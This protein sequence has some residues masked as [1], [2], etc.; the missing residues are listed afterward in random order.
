MDTIFALASGVLPSGVA[1]VRLSGPRA[2][3][4]AKEIA[5]PLPT[6]RQVG[7]RTIRNRNN[8]ALDQGVVVAFEGPNSF[9]GEDVVEFQLHGSVAV[10]NALSAILDSFEGVRQAE[11]GEFTQRAFMNGR[12]DLTAAEGLASLID[13][14]TEA[15]RQYA[16]RQATGEAYAVYRGWQEQM[17][18]LRAL[19]E[20]EIDFSDEDGVSDDVGRRIGADA[21]ELADTIEQHLAHAEG[22]RQIRDGVCVVL[23]GAPNVGKSSLFNALLGEDR[24]LVSPVAGTTRDYIEARLDIGGVLV[25]LIDTAGLRHG[26]DEVEK[27]GI[28]R[29]YAMLEKADL[30]IALSEEGAAPAAL[31]DGGKPVLRF[32]TKCD[33][34]A[35]GRRI[36]VSDPSSIARVRAVVKDAVDALVARSIN[37]TPISQR[38]VSYLRVCVEELRRVADDELDHGLRGEKLRAASEALGRITGNFGVEDVLGAIF[39]R[40]CVGK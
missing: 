23:A 33:D 17:L 10:V 26:V 24:V 2:F 25:R 29:S 16:L 22:A 4:V 6:L 31:P 32:T 39:S 34:D 18:G 13:A 15:Q 9:T 11:A 30:I 19:S 8:E 14:E 40:F 21:A 12:F 7:L 38:H 5:G 28:E 20:A 27:A 36:S 1:V 3:T 35:V 37:A